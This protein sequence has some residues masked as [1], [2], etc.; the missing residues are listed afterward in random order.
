MGE[1]AKYCA[2][3]CACAWYI[4]IGIIACILSKNDIYIYI[5]IKLYFYFD[6]SNAIDLYMSRER[7]Y[8]MRMTSLYENNKNK[9]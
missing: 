2:C 1:E 4:D 7:T 3:A 9:Y 5:Y 8:H 6:I